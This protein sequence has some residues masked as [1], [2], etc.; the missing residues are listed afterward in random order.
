M[1]GGKNEKE[2]KASGFLAWLIERKDKGGRGQATYN[3]RLAPLDL[4]LLL[5]HLAYLRFDTIPASSPLKQRLC[6]H[7][8]SRRGSRR[9]G[10]LDL[11]LEGL[12]RGEGNACP[13]QDLACLC[14]L[15]TTSLGQGHGL[16]KL[17]PRGQGEGQAPVENLSG[18]GVS[19]AGHQSDG[20]ASLDATRRLHAHHRASTLR[21]QRGEEVEDDETSGRKH[22]GVREP[23]AS[24]CLC[25]GEGWVWMREG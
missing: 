18:A 10:G 19:Q 8:P 12:V 6:Y 3:E 14:Q 22:G 16:E 2:G 24:V 1:E 25:G 15:G 20:P 4:S 13:G 7:H 23:H 9:H 11:E 21:V 5:H 17:H